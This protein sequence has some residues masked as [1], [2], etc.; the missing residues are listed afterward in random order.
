MLYMPAT[1]LA[2]PVVFQETK[3]VPTTAQYYMLQPT[4]MVPTV[5]L[6]TTSFVYPAYAFVTKSTEKTDTTKS[7]IAEGIN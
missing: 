7:Q 4:S 6:L 5:P 3:P 1:T 2:T